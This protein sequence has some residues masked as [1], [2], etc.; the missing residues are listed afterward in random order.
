MSHIESAATTARERYPAAHRLVAGVGERRGPPHRQ[1]LRMPHV[2]HSRRRQL[3]PIVLQR[4]TLVNTLRQ[5]LGGIQPHNRTRSG[6][7]IRRSAQ[8]P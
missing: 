6:C 2:V 7:A 5:L 1:I 4:Q 3:Y 8:Q